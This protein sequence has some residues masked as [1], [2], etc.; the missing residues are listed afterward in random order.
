[1]LLAA[2]EIFRANGDQAS[3]AMTLV[4][5]SQARLSVGEVDDAITAAEEAIAIARTIGHPQAET[6]AL[7][8]LGSAH[9]FNRNVEQATRHFQQALHLAEKS[10]MARNLAHIHLALVK[11]CFYCK[12]FKTCKNHASKALALAGE[13]GE[14]SIATLSQASTAA[15]EACEGLFHAGLRKL[16]NAYKGIDQIGD[17]EMVIQLKALLGQVLLWHGKTDQDREE[18]RGILNEGLAMARNKGLAPEVSFIE[19]ILGG[20][21]P[22]RQSVT[23]LPSAR[24][25]SKAPAPNE[26]ITL[27]VDPGKNANPI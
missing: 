25:G 2:G 3:Y 17:E 22:S 16:Q 6:N 5:I 24:F 1:M 18:G 26:D 23:A 27:I 14:K 20:D 7:M 15:V 4:N 10:S 12:D 19:E 11:L 13:L 21:A 8:Q 9:F